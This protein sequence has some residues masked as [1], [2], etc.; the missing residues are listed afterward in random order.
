MAGPI[1]GRTS[2]LLP[3]CFA[4]TLAVPAQAASVYAVSL[5]EVTNFSMSGSNTTFSGFTFSNDSVVMGGTGVANV[6]L[7]DA[8][9][10]CV[11][12][13]CTG[14]NNDFVAHGDLG[15]DYTYADAEILN[16]DVLSGAGAASAIAESAI[17]AGT[18]FAQAANT[19]ISTNFYVGTGGDTVSLSFDAVPYLETRVSGAGSAAANLALSVSLT[20][21]GGTTPIYSWAP[22]SVGIGSNDLYDPGGVS[23]MDSV[24]LRAGNYSLNIAM[25]QQVN[26]SA[27]PLPGALW[28]FGAGLAGLVGVARRR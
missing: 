8:P 15:S 28:L 20:E 21:L 23:F 24:T 12:T 7:Q 27:V 5:T 2:A 1:F 9:A 11:G 13:P 25:T 16:T 3:L 14:F 18:A 10:A 26:V 6:D 22:L 4:A 19:L 17:S